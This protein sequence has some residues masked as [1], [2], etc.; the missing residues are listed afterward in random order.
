MNARVALRL[1]W[2]RVTRGLQLTMKLTGDAFPTP[3]SW[4]PARGDR[5]G[6]CHRSRGV[7]GTASASAGGRI[8]VRERHLFSADD[9]AHQEALMAVMT[10][11]PVIATRAA[12]P[13]IRLRYLLRCKVADAL[14]V[15]GRSKADPPT[16][17]PG[18]S[19]FSDSPE[20]RA[21]VLGRPSMFLTLLATLPKRARDPRV[22]PHR[23]AV[24]RQNRAVAV[25][26][27]AGAVQ[28]PNT[29]R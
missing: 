26:S 23:R 9:V 16:K 4:Q 3:P 27:T 12:I 29:V 20:Q 6:A 14:R 22:A 21:I 11:L 25:D 24:R 28:W 19:S 8:G 10:A 18:K 15:A 7:T 2:S 1:R 13:R 17:M 5:G